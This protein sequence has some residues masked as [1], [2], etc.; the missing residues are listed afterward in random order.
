MSPFN[1]ALMQ[2]Y[3]AMDKVASEFAE[4]VHAGEDINNRAVLNSIIHK[5]GLDHDGFSVDYQYIIKEAKA[6]L[7]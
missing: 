5:Y 4:R 3:E 7:W 1:Y 6:H 2:H